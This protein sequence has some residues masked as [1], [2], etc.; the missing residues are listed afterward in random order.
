M[1]LDYFDNSPNYDIIKQKTGQKP[2]LV[3]LAI[4]A[5]LLLL[6]LLL[7]SINFFMSSLFCYALPAMLSILALE[8]D[9]TSFR[10]KCLTFWILFSIIEI[11]TAFLNPILGSFLTLILRIGFTI[12]ALHPQW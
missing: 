2:S 10:E 1:G 3:I 12:V 5:V 8:G 4:G 7:H 11:V 9:Q 6:S